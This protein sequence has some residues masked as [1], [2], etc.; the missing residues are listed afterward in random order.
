MKLFI[1]VSPLDRSMPTVP[2]LLRSGGDL[3]DQNMWRRWSFSTFFQTFCS[4]SR[5][6]T[7]S[8][9]RSR[10]CCRPSRPPVT[11]ASGRETLALPA[12]LG[13]AADGS[14]PLAFTAEEN[15]SLSSN[16]N[17]LSNNRLGGEPDIHVPLMPGR[18][19]RHLSA[20]DLR[21]HWTVTAAPHRRTFC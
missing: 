15:K 11:C 10:S 20:A 1:E 8:T 7:S 18:R 3:L 12:A 4:N 16:N 13:V 14:V 9:G 5:R 2:L 6:L 21:G 19:V 17:P